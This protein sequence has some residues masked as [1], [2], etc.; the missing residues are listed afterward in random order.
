M[1]AAA[2]ALTGLS[3]SAFVTALAF[4]R[5]L[6]DFPIPGTESRYQA[7][8]NYDLNYDLFSQKGVRDL[9]RAE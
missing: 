6:S 8:E 2:P 9:Q 3:I 1:R 4:D 7:F 5:A